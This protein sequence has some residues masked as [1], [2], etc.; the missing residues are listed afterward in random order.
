MPQMTFNGAE[1]VRNDTPT[2]SPLTV[3]SWPQVPAAGLLHAHS[4]YLWPEA[5]W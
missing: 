3:P 1:S 4:Q 2:T 5:G